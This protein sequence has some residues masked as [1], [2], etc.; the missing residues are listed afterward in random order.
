MPVAITTSRAST[1]VSSARTTCGLSA[2]ALTSTACPTTNLTELGSW[3]RTTLT[4]PGRKFRSAACGAVDDLA[5]TG[6]DHLV[7]PRRCRRDAIEEPEPAQQLDLVAGDLLD[8]ELRRIGA[9]SIDQR[10]P[11]AGA[12]REQ[13]RQAI[14]PVPRRR[15][16]YPLRICGAALGGASMAQGSGLYFMTPPL[17]G[18]IGKTVAI[19]R[20][21]RGSVPLSKIRYQSIGTLFRT[22]PDDLSRMRSRACPALPAPLAVRSAPIRRP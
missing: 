17:F 20:S 8:P 14:R 7:E 15:P 18:G 11:V 21:S 19:R 10:N 4:N 22:T 16:R 12:R 6:I 2:S 13:P 1:T 9:I 3:A 5:V